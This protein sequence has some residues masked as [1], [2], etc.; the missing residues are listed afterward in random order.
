[1]SSCSVLLR[2]QLNG[3]VARYSPSIPTECI[4]SSVRFAWRTRPQSSDQST[5]PLPQSC[6]PGFTCFPSRRQEYH[7]QQ[8]LCCSHL[9]QC[10][11]NHIDTT[12]TDVHY[13]DKIVHLN[14]WEFAFDLPYALMCLLC[15]SSETAQPHASE[16][17]H[18][19]MSEPLVQT[20]QSKS[21]FMEGRSFVLLCETWRSFAKHSNDLRTLGHITALIDPG[22]SYC[23]A[24]A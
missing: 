15:S 4:Y 20:T 16:V 23:S 21:S 19:L 22:I 7:R 8:S 14:F 17:V 24:M 11:S 13:P 6:R 3:R 2:A 12:H 9:S 5:L 1:M 18:C 10:V